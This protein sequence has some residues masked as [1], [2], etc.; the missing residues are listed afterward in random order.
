M[1]LDPNFESISKGEGL[2]MENRGHDGVIDVASFKQNEDQKKNEKNAI[3][4][5]VPFGSA[6]K[7]IVEESR[8]MQNGSNSSL[9]DVLRKIEVYGS[10]LDRWNS[11]KRENM[12]KEIKTRRSAL[13]LANRDT[14]G[15]NWKQIGKLEEQLSVAEEMEES[16]QLYVDV[17]P[18]S[19]KYVMHC[20]IPMREAI[21]RNAGN[22]RTDL[23][24]KPPDDGCYK[25]NCSAVDGKG[26]YKTGIGVVIR[27]WRGEVMASCAQYIDGSFDG[28]VASIIAVYKGIMFSLDCGLR[29]CIF[30]SDKTNVINR[31]VNK[32]HRL[33][34]Y[35]HIL[36][37]IEVLKRDN[38]STKFRSTSK[39]ANRVAQWLTKYG[40]ESA[41]NMFLMEDVLGG[42]RDLVEVEKTV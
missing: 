28:V 35:G 6:T 31:I 29:P 23:Q 24:W 13:S 34:N 33:S 2:E 4:I 9:N 20:K 12:L 27:N 39:V 18:W 41:D 15:M 25:V 37:E 30:E 11:K 26:D 17:F 42:I 36:D 1:V 19:C 38:P 5:S 8:L 40:L 14:S 22:N 10:R 3:N 32:G 16:N 7:E 21:L